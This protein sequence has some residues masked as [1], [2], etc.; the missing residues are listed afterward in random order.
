MPWELGLA[1][2]VGSAATA[3]V[4]TGNSVRSPPPAPVAQQEP[5]LSPRPHPLASGPTSCT[6]VTSVTSVASAEP[7]S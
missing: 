3:A 5:R 4:T 7:A 1:R 6:S 2:R